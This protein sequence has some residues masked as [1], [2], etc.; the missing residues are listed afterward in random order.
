M[1][2]EHLLLVFCVLLFIALFPEGAPPGGLLARCYPVHGLLPSAFFLALMIP[3]YWAARLIIRM[4]GKLLRH[5]PSE[6]AVW[7]GRVLVDG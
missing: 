2:D 5:L 6:E 3:I 7:Y 1:H 4:Y